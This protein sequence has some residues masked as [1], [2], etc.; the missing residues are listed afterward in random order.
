[1]ENQKVT[2]R[3]WLKELRIGFLPVVILIMAALPVPIMRA[4][5]LQLTAAVLLAI[6]CGAIAHIFWF[7]YGTILND[8]YDQDIDRHHPFGEKMFTKGY[9]TDAQ[10]KQVVLRF[11]ILA[12]VFEVPQ[13]AYIAFTHKNWLVDLVAFSVLIVLGFLAA[14]AYSAPPVRTRNRLLGATYTLMFVF[15]VAFLRF[16]ILLGGWNFVLNNPYQV[17]AI[18]AFI[19]LGHGISTVALKDIPDAYSDQKGGVRS[20]PLVHGFKFALNITV[21]TLAMT[22]GLGFYLVLIG[23]VQW[24]FLLTYVGVIVYMFLLRDTR[25]F[26]DNVTKDPGTWLTVPMRRTHHM[27]GYIMNWAV[28]IPGLML[29]FNTAYLV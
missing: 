24:W 11:A 28:W 18:C 12:T 10:K 5:E 3:V 13:G 6:A 4:L 9:F 7:W 16:A 19:W 29:A 8:Y 14:T 26:V 22:L 25:K 20:I 21:A 2:A 27:L 15:V 1:M 17:L 23:W